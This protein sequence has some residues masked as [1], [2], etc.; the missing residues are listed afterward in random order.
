VRAQDAGRALRDEAGRV[1]YVLPARRGGYY[2]STTR[3]GGPAEE[4]RYR[5][6]ES[7][8]PE[9]APSM[10]APAPS[11]PQPVRRRQWLMALIAALVALGSIAACLWFARRK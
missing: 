6:W 10:D 1:F 2:G 5:Q 8:S 7:R 3:T 9:S 11:A 4:E